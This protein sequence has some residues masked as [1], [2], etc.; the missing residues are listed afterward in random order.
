M[1]IDD[2]NNDTSAQTVRQQMIELLMEG[3]H[4]A[5]ELSQE[6]RISE[7]EVYKHLPHIARSVA[8]RKKK[9][10][11]VPSQCSDCGYVFKDR[12]RFTKPGRCPHCKG[13][14]LEQPRY[15]II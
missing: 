7:K 11:V 14:H 1:A 6:L 10:L 9:L 2:Q 13:G 3:R 15:E 5:R 12:T 8:S 4:N